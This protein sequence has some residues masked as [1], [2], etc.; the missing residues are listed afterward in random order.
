MEAAVFFDSLTD[1]LRVLVTD[2]LAYAGLIVLLRAA[3]KR[4]LTKLNA[5][6]SW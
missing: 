1:M 3:G 5:F 4:T 6:D 2:V